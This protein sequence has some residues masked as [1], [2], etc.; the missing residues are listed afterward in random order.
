MTAAAP[1]VRKSTVWPA[2]LGVLL[3]IVFLYWALHGVKWGE[4]LLRIRAA[5]PLLYV[6]SVAAVTLTFPLRALR[7]RI[8]LQAGGSDAPLK[9]VWDATAI[10]FMANNIFPARSGEF[11]RAIATAR[12][13]GPPASTSLAAIAVERVFD[14]IAIVL[15]FA[16]SIAV[17]GLPG[18]PAVGDISVTTLARWGGMVFVGALLVLGMMAHAPEG[19]VRVAE[20]LVQRV[21]PDRW[22]AL[23]QRLI[24]NGITGLAVLRRPRDFARVVVWSFAVWLANAASM[25]IGFYAFD[26]A[27]LP[28]AAA[29]FL[30]GLVAFGAAFPS[31]PG[32]FG[33]F[34]FFSKV[35][36][37]LYGVSGD[38]AIGFAIGIHLGWFMPITLI[39]LAI[40]ARRGLSFGELR[41]ARQ[42][43]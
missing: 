42:G 27:G 12:L 10:G 29:L 33:P 6:A 13:V 26:L 7:F 22:S 20:R 40:L 25:A 23:A 14:G 35:A 18:S 38:A 3:S 1:A 30:Q 36:L 39:G 32:F 41:R 31:S 16:L 15:L 43:P 17:P 34:E 9:P 4:V 37:G 8:L 2:L 19:A 24:R 11:I 21:L 28:F 5:D